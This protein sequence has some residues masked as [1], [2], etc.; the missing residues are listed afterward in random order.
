MVIGIVGA[1]DRAVA[2]ARLLRRCGHTITFSD[3]RDTTKAERAA[4]ALNDGTLAD[5]AYNQAATSQALLMVVHW[6][7]LDLTLA[8]IGDY[9]DGLVIDAIRVPPLT[10]EDN[11]AQRL[12]KKLDNRHVVKAFVEPPDPKT[13]VQVAANDP[14][15]RQ[16]VC[17]M[18]EAC[19]GTAIDL[20]PLSEATR[21]EKQFAA[22]TK[23]VRGT[24]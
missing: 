3:P 7:D 16:A 18:I 2:I 10:G 17:E 6:E 9:K 11:G 24:V 5:T 23:S 14:E 21:I 4:A 13:P 1:D 15:A 12:A 20:G 8:S 22:E 19:G